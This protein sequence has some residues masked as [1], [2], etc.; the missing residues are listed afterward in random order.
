MTQI[1]I[2]GRPAPAGLA[3][4]LRE[5]RA[6]LANWRIVHILGAADIQRR[7]ARSRLGQAWLTLSTAFTAMILGFVWTV[8]WKM[9]ADEILPHV[10]VGLILWTMIS[11]MLIEASALPATSAHFMANQG[12]AFSTFVYALIY[13]NILIFAHNFVIIVFSVLYF[14]GLGRGELL[15]FI[16]AFALTLICAFFLTYLIAMLSARYRD[17][18]HVV[19]GLVQLAF[20]VTPILWK[21]EL[22]PEGY[23]W[24]LMINPIV[25]FIS[26]MRDPLLA[27]PISMN[28][29][30]AALSL[31]ACLGLGVLY[32]VG[33]WRRKI[34]YWI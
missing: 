15:T 10:V 29:W 28:N 27:N 32:L 22:L 19:T 21:P 17:L 26:I 13:R 23:E 7:Y 4:G 30:L 24:L 9:P 33:R 14:K 6:G 18:P 1:E 20:Y 25:P 12:L 16:P 3:E 5:C 11:A 2:T 34:I 8:L 31:T